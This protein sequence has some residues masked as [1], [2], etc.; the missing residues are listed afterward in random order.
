MEGREGGML[1]V[2]LVPYFGSGTGRPPLL[3]LLRP[4]SD[5]RPHQQADRGVEGLEW[6]DF[7]PERRV[8][9][10]EME[11]GGEAV[12]PPL[13]SF[14]SLVGI[15]SAFILA[16]I[17]LRLTGLQWTKASSLAWCTNNAYSAANCAFLCYALFV[18]HKTNLWQTWQASD[19]ID[20]LPREVTAT[21]FLVYYYSKIWEFVDLVLVML[22]GVAIH[23]HFSVH[24]TTTLTLA[25]C[26]LQYRTLS[27]YLF[28]LA[29]VIMHVFLY[30]YFGGL[31]APW[32]FAFL[33]LWGHVQL[34]FGMVASGT[35][36]YL[37]MASVHEN[38]TRERDSLESKSQRLLAVAVAEGVPFILYSTYLVLYRM[39]IY[40]QQKDKA[41]KRK[42]E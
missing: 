40:D 16:Q 36:M 5:P 6:A 25:W 15:T 37:K 27:G 21:A 29:N 20:P 13:T 35:A 18:L 32:V 8:V 1:S 11:D 28:M 38:A 39:E 10:S 17:L 33:R 42:A 7:V 2:A 14:S 12:Y 34:V 41:A 3:V 23:P 30:A 26:F 31:R 9:L 24:H 4:P 19:F 22:M